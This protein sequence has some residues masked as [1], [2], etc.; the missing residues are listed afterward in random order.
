MYSKKYLLAKLSLL[1]K[2]YG[3]MPISK[4]MK[5]QANKKGLL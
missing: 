1:A 4:V 2:L 5:I 3:N